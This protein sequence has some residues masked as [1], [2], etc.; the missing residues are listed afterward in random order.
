MKFAR[1]GDLTIHY[2]DEGPRAR[3]AVVF[4]NSLG[5]DLRIWDDV[6]P[7]I[8]ERHRVIRYDTR[9][10]GLSSA[11]PG[12]ARMDDFVADLEGLLDALAVERVTLIGLSI[13]GMI[14]QLFHVSHPARLASLVLCC[15]AHRIGT[16]ESWAARIETVR[17]GGIAAVADVTM[18]RWFTANFRASRTAELEG[19]R[20]MLTR[21]P[22]AGY[23]A[24][25]AALRD[26]DLTEAAKAIAVPTTC[27]A[28][29]EDG[30]TPVDLV[31]ALAELVPGAAFQ[32]IDQ[33]AHIPCVEQPQ[34]MVRLLEQHLQEAGHG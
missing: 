17:A 24:G 9:G 34:A 2:A 20:N 1:V 16:A 11:G 10:H 32:V 19:A 23:I 5:S 29:R 26:A 14:A 18:E 31:R 12:E 22:L 27:V 28:G 8:A 13:G 30:S 3:D 7:A 4:V 6:A 21:T 25:C 33:A 15:T